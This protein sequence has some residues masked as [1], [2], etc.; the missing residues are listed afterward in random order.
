MLKS[1]IYP[2]IRYKDGVLQ[3]KIEIGFEAPT[4]FRGK[5]NNK[6]KNKCYV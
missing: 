4:V 1:G 3:M 6:N 2:V 5:R